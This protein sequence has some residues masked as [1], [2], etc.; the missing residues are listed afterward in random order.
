MADPRM[1]CL[2]S[3]RTLLPIIA[4]LSMIGVGAFARRISVERF[5]W[6]RG[7][8]LK[9]A[10]A[11]LAVATACLGALFIFDRI[12]LTGV[13]Q[14]LASSAALA[15]GILSLGAGLAMLLGAAAYALGG[16]VVKRERPRHSNV[17]IAID[18]PAA[19]GKGTLAKRVAAHYGLPC[20]DTGLLYRAVARDVVARGGSLE[21]SNDG[22]AAAQALDAG[23]LTD[24][25]L[26]GP[27][28]G[29]RASVVAKISAVRAA[30][31]DYQRSFAARPGG[32]VLDGRDIGTVVC[33]QANVKLFVTASVEERARRRHLEH[34][35]RGESV[36]LDVVLAEL[37][38]RDAR[39]SGRD[40]APMMQAPDAVLIDTTT[41]D[42]DAAFA[43]ALKAIGDTLKT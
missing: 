41:L 7:V 43:A 6:M 3:W 18:G 42:A 12:A 23:T 1:A 15:G 27:A 39:D 8:A 25:A 31:L 35:A 13:S 5:R 14:S 36:A 33:P 24:P 34:K 38:A 40:I 32:A 11:L 22:V 16:W 30:L 10:A 9:A 26:R 2:T 37:K 29:D 19:S 17:L 28:A 21:N 4:L 20:L